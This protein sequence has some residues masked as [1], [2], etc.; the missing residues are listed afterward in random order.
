MNDLNFWCPIRCPGGYY[1]FPDPESMI[2]NYLFH[3]FDYYYVDDKSDTF[4]QLIGH[5]ESKSELTEKNHIISA[6][7]E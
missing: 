4:F 3:Y 6:E 7:D 1:K 2:P 5:I